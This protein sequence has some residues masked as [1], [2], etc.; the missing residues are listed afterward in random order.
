MTKI[1]ITNKCNCSLHCECGYNDKPDYLQNNHTH[2]PK[3]KKN[4]PLESPKTEKERPTRK[5]SKQ[6]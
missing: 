2:K 3:E 5:S 1:E 4:T 6:K